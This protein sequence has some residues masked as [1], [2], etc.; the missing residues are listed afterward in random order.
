MERPL[1]VAHLTH[2]ADLYGANRSLLDLLDGFRLQGAVLSHVILPRPGALCAELDARGVPWHLIPFEPWLSEPYS[3]GH[4]YHRVQQRMDQGRAARHRIRANRAILSVIHAWCM[5]RKIDLLHANSAAVGVV[6]TLVE[7]GWLPLVWHLRELPEAH[8]RMVFDGGARRYRLALE[9]AA[10]LIAI[11]DTV[12][13]DIHQ[14]IGGTRVIH[15]VY[16]GLFDASELAAQRAH[17]FARHGSEH[18]FTFLMVGLIHPSKGQ[19]EAVEAL[20]IVRDK[21]R[22][23]RLVVVGGGRTEPVHKRVRELGLEGMVEFAGYQ[24]TVKNYFE[25]ADAYLACSQHEAL[26]RSTIEAMAHGV[27]VIALRSG[28]HPEV[29]LADDQA[30]GAEPCGLLF[31]GGAEFL[32]QRM[33]QVMDDGRLRA[34]LSKR[35]FA[36]LTG[37]F[38]RAASAAE[39]TAIFQRAVAEHKKRS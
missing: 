19:L 37:R 4:W 18:M 21:G 1:R 15:R 3:S 26:G 24:P 17:S 12:V 2:Y 29:L 16:D 33:C 7:A 27:P 35:A 38:D 39:V 28:A 9:R 30:Q 34:D 23:A 31:E 8:Y 36:S 6:P 22:S 32:A 20:A 25:A 5:D 14:R 10:A 13:H 11:S